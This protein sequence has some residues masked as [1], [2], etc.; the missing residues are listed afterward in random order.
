MIETKNNATSS[1][2][3]KELNTKIPLPTMP[4]LLNF[5]QKELSTEFYLKF[6]Q[7]ISQP[8][9]AQA[10][11]KNFLEKFM[12][13]NIVL[14]GVNKKSIDQH[15]KISAMSDLVKLYLIIGVLVSILSCYDK[16]ITPDNTNSNMFQIETTIQFY[17]DN[18]ESES[19]E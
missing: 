14:A 6:I 5:A 18:K 7:A 13:M 8:D 17:D 16:F 15:G 3:N 11:Q 19:T 1:I 4:E 10:I 12:M 2:S 9:I